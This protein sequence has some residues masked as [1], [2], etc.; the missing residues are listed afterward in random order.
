MRSDRTITISAELDDS[1]LTFKL[2]IKAKQG[3]PVNR[4]RL[5]FSGKFL[6]DNDKTVPAHT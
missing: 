2:K 4:Q 6:R 1:V 5:C 3:F